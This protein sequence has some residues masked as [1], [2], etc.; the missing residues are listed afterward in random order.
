MVLG[1]SAVVK[2]VKSAGPVIDASP[3]GT[4]FPLKAPTH[5]NP[6]QPAHAINH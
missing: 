1:L 4:H 3:P 6:K 5:P 2:R